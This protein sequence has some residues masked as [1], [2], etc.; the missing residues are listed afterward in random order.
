MPEKLAATASGARLH[1][2]DAP[3][4]PGPVPAKINVSGFEVGLRCY[5]IYLSMYIL[6]HIIDDSSGG[7]II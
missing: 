7:L 6:L 3:F 1:V 4:R 2:L 5:H